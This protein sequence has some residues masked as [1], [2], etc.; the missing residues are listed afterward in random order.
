MPDSMDFDFVTAPPEQPRVPWGDIIAN[1]EPGTGA[2]PRLEA[3]VLMYPDKSRF[4]LIP[5]VGKE[6]ILSSAQ[7]VAL[8]LQLK[9]SR[10]FSFRRHRR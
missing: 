6:E 2:E 3:R 8:I 4:F 5:V 7:F 9:A 10:R 1:P